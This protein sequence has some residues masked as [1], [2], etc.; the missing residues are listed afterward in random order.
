MV[1][2]VSTADLLTVLSDH[3][4]NSLDASGEMEA[5]ALDISKAFDKV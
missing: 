4:Y 5:V 2:V 1:F 3:I